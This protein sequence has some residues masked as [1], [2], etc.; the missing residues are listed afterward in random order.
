MMAKAQKKLVL[1][2]PRIIALDK[3]ERSEANVRKV[4]KGLTIE[5]LADDIDNRGLL[6]NLGAR[7]I[8][9]EAGNET[10]RFQVT[11]GGRRREALLLLV[12]RKRLAKDAPIPCM[13][14]TEGVAEDDSYTE[15]D[16]RIGLHPLDQFRAFKALRD[17]GLSEEEIAARHFVSVDIVRQ[18]LRLTTVSPK[19]LDLY[20]EEQITYGQLTA[21]SIVQDHARQEQVWDIVSR[22]HGYLREPYHIRRMLTETA[23][24]ADDFRA[25]FV[26]IDAYERAGGAVMRDLFQQD[27]GGWLQDVGLLDS[28]ALEKL[29]AAAQEVAAEG[30]KWV[31]I[32]LQFPYGAYPEARHLKGAVIPPTSEEEAQNQALIEELERLEAAHPDFGILPDDVAARTEEIN[33]TLVAREDRPLVYNPAERAIAGALVSIDDDGQLLVERG[34]VRP[35]DEPA[36]DAGEEQ[37]ADAAASDQDDRAAE[38][39][40]Q[41]AIITIGGGS[42]APAPDE[43]AEEEAIK[44][45]PD[46]LRLE[47]SAVRTV[48]LQN[49]VA[50]DPD[51]A[52]TLL[53]HT[54]CRA[55]FSHD[56]FGGCLEAGVNDVQFVVQGPDLKGTAAAKAIKERHA[57]WKSA[58]PGDEEALWQHLVQLGA[59]ERSSLL[60]HLVAIG[61]NAIDETVKYDNGRVSAHGVKRRLQAADRLARAVGLD[62]VAEGW[63]PTYDNYLSR[64]TKPRILAAVRESKGE[65]TAQLID[66][67]KKGDMAREAERLLAGSG[68]LPE[69]LRLEPAEAPAAAGEQGEALPEFLA[70]DEDDGESEDAELPMAAE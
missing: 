32:A 19:L 6:Q 54:L 11:Y 23:V 63:Q 15:N 28:L 17:K 5:A 41:R 60:A 39:E 58:L 52:M 35:E 2:L 21:F 64:V 40:I 13:V 55:A 31:E 14:R 67:L 7:P 53:L 47:L 44:P 48:A 57:S 12:E 8:Y 4:K 26:G 69:P 20:V 50:N 29:N 61:I 34:I 59:A 45:L 56:R 18:R 1:T 9:D 38:P 65:H 51:V 66:H 42:A 30:W 49:A 70:G 24:E 3:L 36:D 25:V 46:V 27:G 43:A 16:Q 10:D 68:W 33:Q 37:G 22:G 62:M